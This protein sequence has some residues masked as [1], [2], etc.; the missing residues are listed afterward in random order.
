MIIYAVFKSGGEYEDHYEEIVKCFTDL[1]KAEEFVDWLT[2]EEE[3][4]RTV[5]S[6]CMNCSGD[7]RTCPMWQESYDDSVGCNNWYDA[8]HM[9]EYYEIKDVELIGD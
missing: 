3:N 6:K 1:K 8:Y 5:A 2:S 4:A 7:D 9:N